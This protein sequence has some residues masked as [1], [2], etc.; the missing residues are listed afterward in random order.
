LKTRSFERAEQLKRKIEDGDAPRKSL[1][2]IATA[3]Q[4]FLLDVEHGRKLQPAT[5]KKYRVLLDQLQAFATKKNVADISRIDVDFCRE[6]RGSWADGAISSSKKLERLRAFCRFLSE[7]GWLASN[8]AKAV[9]TPKIHDV[10]TL[11]FTDREILDILKEAT[12]PRWHALIQVLRWS[13]LRI[14]DAMELTKEK[15]DGNR[16]F[17]HMA[18]TKVPVHVPIPDFVINELKA[19]P[20][21]GGYFFW[22][23][24]GNSKVDTAT[25]NAR[26]TLRKIFATAKIQPYDAKEKKSEAHPHRFR[27]TFAVGLLLAGVPIEQVSVLLGHQ[28]VKIT[29]KHYSPWVRSRQKNLERAVTGA[30]PKAQL[31]LVKK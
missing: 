16:I 29:E 28:S 11:P 9:K 3:V 26:R 6:F 21:F 1:P 14:G 24:E 17:L 19:L 15:V 20:T 4:K 18:K 10:P 2:T 7:S 30:W 27:D 8:P 22:K 12:D 31:A 23:R 5:I 25:G 13:G